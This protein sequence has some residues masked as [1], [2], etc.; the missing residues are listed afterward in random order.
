[1]NHKPDKILHF[2]TNQSDFFLFLSL[3][4]TYFLNFLTDII[5]IDQDELLC[6]SWY[7]FVLYLIHHQQE[8]ICWRIIAGQEKEKKV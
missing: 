1:M 3:W 4:S 6:E 5:G 7:N 8:G 2:A